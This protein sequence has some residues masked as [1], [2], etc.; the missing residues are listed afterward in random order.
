M[1]YPGRYSTS[2]NAYAGM[3]K[4]TIAILL[5][6]SIL[7]FSFFTSSDPTPAE[8]L[9]AYYNAHFVTLTQKIDALQQSVEA[10][11]PLKEI[12]VNFYDARMAYKEM[13]IFLEYYFEPDVAK[14]NGLAV[15]FI[16]EEDPT[17]YQEPQGFQMIETF[18]YPAYQKK[19]K[20]ELIRYITKL[21]TVAKGLS[22]NNTLFNP[23]N[24]APDAA[25][26]ELYRILALGISGFDSPIAQLSLPEASA[27]LNSV[28]FVIETYAPEINEA[29]GTD[30]PRMQELIKDAKHY[31]GLHSNFNNFNRAFFITS[32]L[33][34][35]CTL[36][37]N[38]KNRCGYPANPA[39]YTLIKKTGHLFDAKSLN[40][41]RYLY[42]DTINPARI[43]LGKQLFYEPLLSANGKRSCAGCHQ[44]GKSF[45]DGLPKALQVDE[46]SLLP[47]NTPAL[48]NASLQMN[49]F[50]DSRQKRLDDVV[51]E[52]LSNDKEMNSGSARAAEKLN[53]S[54]A[55]V[56]L[57]KTTYPSK[58][59]VITDRKIAN[60]IAMY[61]RTLISY[62][63]RFDQYMR[64]D[65]TKMN[66]SEI[67]GFNI[68]MGKAKCA[69]CHY[70]PL[71]NGSKPPTY[72]Y[73]ES[74]VIGVP[75]N[76]NAARP[77]PDKDPG[78][79]TSLKVDFFNHAFK[80]PTLRNIALTAPYMHN[81]VYATLD[82]VID[83]Y[84]KG[85][86]QGLGLTLPNQTLPPDK[87]LLTVAEKK[88]LKAFLLTL[89]DTSAMNY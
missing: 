86:G 19:N 32:W 26:E 59:T 51:M 83:F 54:N 56:Q 10:D 64:G 63:S 52:V 9:K 66:I 62:N 38:A 15:N 39:R 89:T 29:K 37:G 17:A 53:T 22:A 61:I 13:E 11:R 33:N 47:R 23:E 73:Q 25:M 60:A 14:F 50:Y 77:V 4:T 27:A 78:R 18:I 20:K 85:G 2:L 81:G 48:W 75:A 31:L 5:V 43:Q 74:E 88:A 72:Y 44:P 7:L 87:L 36:L 28:Q 71:F 80:T 40:T 1:L 58:D 68:F 49:L 57:F 70:V 82:Q 65:T 21:G 35:L 41:D 42:D 46:H 6:V 16:E 12:Q 69:T 67:A 45:T 76:R 84:D 34:P 79:I 3:R 8:K 55:Y 24:F 30:Y